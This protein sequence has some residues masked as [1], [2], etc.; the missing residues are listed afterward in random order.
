MPVGD[1]RE[2]IGHYTLP[3]QPRT[4]STRGHLGTDA[5]RLP[6]GRASGTGLEDEWIVQTEKHRPVWTHMS[7]ETGRPGV[8]GCLGQV[9]A[10]DMW[11]QG[12]HSEEP[13]EYSEA[14]C[15]TQQ[16][17]WTPPQRGGSKAN[18]GELSI[19]KIRLNS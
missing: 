7:H 10:Q 4:P 5:K 12:Q 19:Q 13:R 3:P 16:G 6:R 2:P 18:Q 14:S 15:P 9:R 1:A 8:A 11:G 17:A